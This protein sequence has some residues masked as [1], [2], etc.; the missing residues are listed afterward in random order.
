M[1]ANIGR[2]RASSGLLLRRNPT[3]GAQGWN[4]IAMW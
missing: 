1:R 2:F 3:I 4:E